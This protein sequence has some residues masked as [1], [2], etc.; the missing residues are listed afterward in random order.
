MANQVSEWNILSGNLNLIIRNNNILQ[1]AQKRKKEKKKPIY[2]NFFFF[3]S[4]SFDKK[5]KKK[6][7]NS[8][9]LITNRSHKFPTKVK[10]GQTSLFSHESPN[11]MVS[12]KRTSISDELFT[13]LPCTH[14][15]INCIK[16][17]D[18]EFI[19]QWQKTCNFSSGKMPQW[20]HGIPQIHQTW[21]LDMNKRDSDIEMEAL[22]LLLH[23]LVSHV[24]GTYQSFSDWNFP[25]LAPIHL[26]YYYTM[27]S[28]TKAPPWSLRKENIQWS[29][30]ILKTIF[31][32]SQQNLENIK[33]Q[34]AT[35]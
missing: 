10:P 2:F 17:F 8:I 5:K 9:S 15:S 12:N 18:Q 13:F 25:L 32:N 35:I 33:P 4:F 3:F 11:F 26:L 20:Q 23:P 19:Q 6:Q 27:W 14:T 29:I 31:L 28:P 30:K 22:C 21:M 1:S 16:P 7:Y 34:N 24:P